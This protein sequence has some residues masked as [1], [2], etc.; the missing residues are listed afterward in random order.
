MFIFKCSHAHIQQQLLLPRHPV[1]IFFSW[2]GKAELIVVIIKD[3]WTFLSFEGTFISPQLENRDISSHYQTTL[4]FQ[5][6]GHQ[7][8]IR[9][10]LIISD[11]YK[12]FASVCWEQ[13]GPNCS[14][15]NISAISKHLFNFATFIVWKSIYNWIRIYSNNSSPLCPLFG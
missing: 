5:G 2:P 12:N 10:F 6:P 7:T 4:Y 13:D 11:A 1:Y 15:W 9:C 14:H 8:C 3:M